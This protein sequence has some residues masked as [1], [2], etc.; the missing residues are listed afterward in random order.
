MPNKKTRAECITWYEENGGNAGIA[1]GGLAGRFLV[2]IPGLGNFLGGLSGAVYG[3][4]VY[5]AY[6]PDGNQSGRIV[7]SVG[8]TILGAAVPTVASFAGISELGKEI[9]ST[10][11]GVWGQY[12]CEDVPSTPPPPSAR[13]YRAAL[14]P[15]TMKG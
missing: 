4:R 13:K 9:G 11:G 14:P 12:A 6:Y 8:G 5:D 2:S 15:S 7:A 3:A 10:L 1:V